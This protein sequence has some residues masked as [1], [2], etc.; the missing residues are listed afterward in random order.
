MKYVTV[1][2]QQVNMDGT[3]LSTPFAGTYD[4]SLMTLTKNFVQ[5]EHTD[6]LNYIH[7]EISKYD[8]LFQYKNILSGML[9]KGVSTGIIYP[10]TNATL[11]GNERYDEFNIAGYGFAGN[12]GLHVSLWNHFFVRL[13][14]KG[15]FIHMPNIRTT[16][17]ADDKASQ[18]F[19][20]LQTNLLFGGMINLKK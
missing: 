8:T 9:M 3:I 4:D 10:R 20:F 19:F 14:T 12:I 13:N 1:L 11:F 15:G 17:Y 2:D 6:G 18:H 7:L 5:F 16:P